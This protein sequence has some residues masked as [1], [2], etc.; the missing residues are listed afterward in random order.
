M[1]DNNVTDSTDR[2]HAAE[3]TPLSYP[4]GDD[5]PVSEAVIRAVAKHTNTAILDLEPLYTIIDPEYLNGIFEKIDDDG[6]A[7]LSFQ[8][9]GST[10]TV[11]QEVV[12]VTARTET[13]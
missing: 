11:T 5:Q 8:Y 3:P 12:R 9:N 4:I 7:E 1:T 6:T 2:D 13:S 10:V